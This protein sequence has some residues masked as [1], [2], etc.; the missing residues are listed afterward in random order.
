VELKGELQQLA[1]GVVA[2]YINTK[3]AAVAGQLLNVKLRALECERRWREL[4]DVEAR[5]K[6]LEEQQEAKRRGPRARAR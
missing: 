5:L 3:S 6:S 1:D 4:D 2:G